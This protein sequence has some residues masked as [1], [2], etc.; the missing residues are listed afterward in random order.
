MTS[1]KRPESKTLPPAPGSPCRTVSSIGSAMTEIDGQSFGSR[2]DGLQTRRSRGLRR[3]AGETVEDLVGVVRIVV[4]QR[5]ATGAR[6]GRH[7]DGVA[8]GGVAPVGLG[9]ELLLGVLGVVDEQIGAV[10]SSSTLASTWSVCRSEPGGRSRTP[11]WRRRPRCGSR[12]WCPRG[13]RCRTRI[14]AEPMA[15]SSSC[16]LV[17]VD[18][19]VELLHLH[20]EERGD[21]HP[22]DHVVKGAADLG[23]SVDLHAA[24]GVSSGVQNGRPMMWSQCRWVRSAVISMGFSVP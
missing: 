7:V 8:D 23:R 21:H 14:L 13:A 6:L 2:R 1:R 11:H 22:V 24:T 3:H 5:Q 20:G 19:S 17:E 9:L 18:G 16:H 15:K 12:E 4:E 10:A